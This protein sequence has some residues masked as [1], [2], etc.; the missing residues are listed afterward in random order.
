MVH[1]NSVTISP[2]IRA[3]PPVGSKRG[4]PQTSQLTTSVAQPNTICVSFPHSG[5]FT[6]KKRE[7]GSGI[8]LFLDISLTISLD[9]LYFLQSISFPDSYVP[10]DFAFVTNHILL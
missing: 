4:F 2:R 5:H 8:S 3:F 7:V 6:T 9:K 1:S 10:T